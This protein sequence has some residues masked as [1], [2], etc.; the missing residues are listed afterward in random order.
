MGS[1]GH[2]HLVG[3]AGSRGELGMLPPPPHSH[4]HQDPK[5]QGLG[6]LGI[7]SWHVPIT[8]LPGRSMG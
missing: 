5:T 8:L 6:T 2:S 7:A 1:G 4:P 3:E